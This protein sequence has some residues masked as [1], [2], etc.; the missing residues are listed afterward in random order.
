MHAVEGFR[1]KTKTIIHVL[2]ILFCVSFPLCILAADKPAIAITGFEVLGASDYLARLIENR[3]VSNL[4]LADIP[5]VERKN[6]DNVLNEKGLAVSGFAKQDTDT[7]GQLLGASYLISGV[8]DQVSAKPSFTIKVVST[9]DG[10]VRSATVPLMGSLDD[11]VDI[12]SGSVLRSYQ[13]VDY[14]TDIGADL[15]TMPDRAQINIVQNG[16]P[17]YYGGLQANDI[18]TRFGGY[19]VESPY[20]L[21]FLMQLFAPGEDVEVLFTRG[22]VLYKTKVKMR[23]TE[24]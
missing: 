7:K 1:L 10:E 21:W 6:I 8:L 9:D 19:N 11:T 4:T 3:F 13:K 15:R 18:I 23:K 14:T 16:S 20:R 22:T 12:I 24:D 2:L 17:A 5:M